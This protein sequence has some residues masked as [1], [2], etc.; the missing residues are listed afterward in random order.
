GYAQGRTFP[1][2]LTGGLEKP[3]KDFY[4]AVLNSPRGNDLLLDFA[5]RAIDA[6]KLGQ[7]ATQDLLCLSFSSNDL[8]GHCWGPDSQEVLDMTLRTDLIVKDL[9]DTLDAKVGRDRYVVV[10]CADHGVCPSPEASRAAGK[11]AERIAPA[12]LT[13][14]ANA[15][16]NET[17][18]K[19]EQLPWVE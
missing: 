16:L 18:G 9:L 7:G 14:K 19:G 13:T 4:E 17:L 5:K 3:G 10:V 1:H 15:H 2:P 12:L 11:K 8:V 6:E